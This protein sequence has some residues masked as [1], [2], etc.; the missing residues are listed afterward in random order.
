MFLP[1]YSKCRCLKKNNMTSFIHK[2]TN[3]IFLDH[4]A[5]TSI[6]NYPLISIKTCSPK[7][8]HHLQLVIF[9]AAIPPTKV[10]PCSKLPSRFPSESILAMYQGVSENSGFSPQI[11]HFFIGFLGGFLHFWKHPYQGS[12][13]FWL[14]L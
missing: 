12:L 14:P 5:K 13:R 6:P 3:P 10:A 11:I 9:T 4:F 2:T 1:L 8:N 7:K